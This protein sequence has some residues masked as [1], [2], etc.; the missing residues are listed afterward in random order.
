[1]SA[2]EQPSGEPAHD[3]P[4]AI[5]DRRAK[6]EGLRE[7]GIEPFPHSFEGRAEIAAVR[8]AHDGLADGE[9]TEDRY[10]LEIGRAHV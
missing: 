6:L 1:M 5:A 2:D 8:E 3:E 4:G 10:R 7:A 9:E